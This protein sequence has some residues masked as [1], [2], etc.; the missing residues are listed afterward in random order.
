[1]SHDEKPFRLCM[2]VMRW[3]IHSECTQHLLH[4]YCCLSTLLCLHST[5]S[6][7]INLPFAFAKL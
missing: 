4:I 6:Y 2:Y 7:C 1:M 3:C 5:F